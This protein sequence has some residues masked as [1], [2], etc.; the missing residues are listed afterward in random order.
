MSCADAR[1]AIKTG[2]FRWQGGSSVW[3]GGRA[4]PQFLKLCL[5]RVARDV[6][7]RRFKK[8]RRPGDC[9]FSTEMQLRFDK[10]MLV[11]RLGGCSLF[12]YQNTAQAALATPQPCPVAA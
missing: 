2:R 4:P 8:Q 7:G 9:Y 12:Q 6:E 11:S 3:A 1:R 5:M 10:K